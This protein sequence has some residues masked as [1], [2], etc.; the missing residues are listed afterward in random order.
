MRKCKYCAEE[1]QDEARFCKHCKKKL[2]GIP[3]KKIIVI[4]AVL[5]FA[6]FAVTHKAFMRELPYKVKLFFA[7]AKDTWKSFKGVLKDISIGVRAF[8]NYKSQTNQAQTFE[9]LQKKANSK[10]SGTK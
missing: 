1:V 2:R 7:E 4:S 3:V 8:K 5:Y 10:T 6:V 9:V